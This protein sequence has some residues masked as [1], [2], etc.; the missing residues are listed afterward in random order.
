VTIFQC[1]VCEEKFPSIHK[2]THHKI[3][4]S[5]GG[6]DT[7]DNLVE[8]CPQCH[9]LLH[10]VAYKLISKKYNASFL[11]D[12]VKMVYKTN[13]GAV[14]RS[15]ELAFLVR[16]ELIQA[17]ESEKNPNE[18][19]DVYV[20]MRYKHKKKLHE[21]AKA[22]NIS[23]EDMVRNILLRAVSDKFNM[24]IDHKSE[25]NAVRVNKKVGNS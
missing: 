3:P 20:R 16:D 12:M 1:Y 18:F 23:L 15:F 6:K 9:D 22:S 17:K 8:L 13:T 19:V 7:P 4:R 14:K 5:L 24:T 2:H 21:W 10:N 11:E 25:S